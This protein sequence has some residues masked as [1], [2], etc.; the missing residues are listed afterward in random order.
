MIWPNENQDKNKQ[1]HAIF[2]PFFKISRTYA[3]KVTSFSWFRKLA[4][5]I[6]KK[7]PLFDENGYEYEHGCTPWS[8]WGGEGGGWEGWGW[9]GEWVCKRVLGSFTPS[10]KMALCMFM[11]TTSPEWQSMGQNVY[12]Q[13]MYTYCGIY[14]GKM[15]PKQLNIRCY[16]GDPGMFGRGELYLEMIFVAYIGVFVRAARS[17]HSSFHSILGDLRVI[18]I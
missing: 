7:I 4:H 9:N 16:L 18:I 10:I 12:Y 13:I 3:W 11:Y 6:A 17:R 1:I 2:L 5:S 15:A 8:G 14:G